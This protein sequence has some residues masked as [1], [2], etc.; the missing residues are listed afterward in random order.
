SIVVLRSM[1]IR[2]KRF[3]DWTVIPVVWAMI[4]GRPGVMKSP[5]IEEALRPLKQLE[6]EA[7]A[8]HEAA[9]KDW[10]VLQIGAQSRKKSAQ[11]EIDKALK[12]GDP[13]AAKEKARSVIEG[14]TK[15]PRRKRYLS[16][17]ATIEKLGEILRDNPRGIGIHRDELLGWLKMFDRDG[18]E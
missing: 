1:G 16:G 3:D 15:P 18:H 17:D 13:E 14:D 6:M 10:A 2:P 4:I 5:A 7:A 9:M 11:K 8:D 12:A